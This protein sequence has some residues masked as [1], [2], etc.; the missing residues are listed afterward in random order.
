MALLVPRLGVGGV[1]RGAR[2]LAEG[3][4]AHGM[5]AVLVAQNAGPEGIALPVHRKEP[6]TLLRCGALLAREAWDVL[7]PMSRAPAWAAYFAW[8][9]MRRRPLLL[10][11][12]H[13]F[14]RPH[15]YSR[16]FRLAEGVIAVS[17]ALAEYLV[18]R[19]GV[20]EERIRVVYRGVDRKAFPPASGAV[21]REVRRRLGIPEGAP[22]FVL[23]ARPRPYKGH[24]LAVE[25]ISRLPEAHLLLVGAEPAPPW[26]DAVAGK[27]RVHLLP[28]TPDPAPF[29]QAADAALVL[30]T[31]PEA[32]GR[33]ILEAWATG[34]PVVCSDAGALK[35]VFSTL[36]YGIQLS[37]KELLNPGGTDRLAEAL[38]AVWEDEAL[39][40][41]T[42]EEAP[43][44]VAERFPVEKMV[45]ETAD[46]IR[47][48]GAQK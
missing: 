12:A 33:G 17:R 1:E 41:R 2:E 42:R 18:Q 48:F 4:P 39:R 9:K 37:T 24:A 11:S 44:G 32:F 27:A 34:I 8:R 40:R 21:R 35:E 46:A 22:V 15:F 5:E 36:G 38:Q 6:W 23:V 3:L 30:S 20:A 19:L 26:L 14:Y 7:L 47:A 29:L 16:I 25:A 28:P 10:M 45:A 13:G 31:K 43:R